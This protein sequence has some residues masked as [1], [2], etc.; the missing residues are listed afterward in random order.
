MFLTILHRQGVNILNFTGHMVPGVIIV[1]VQCY[2]QLRFFHYR[3]ISSLHFH[4]PTIIQ[5]L[6][7]KIGVW[8]HAA[9]S[10]SS[11][12]YD[13]DQLRRTML[14]KV[15]RLNKLLRKRITFGAAPTEAYKASLEELQ[16]QVQNK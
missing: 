16:A 5:E 11:Y 10:F 3:N 15:K 6:R 13:G 12:S 1:I 9:I 14:K 4:E 8:K 7:H 2:L